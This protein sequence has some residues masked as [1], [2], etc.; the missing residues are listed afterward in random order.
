M[1]KLEQLSIFR[2][3]K[4]TFSGDPN[5]LHI[6]IVPITSTF[7]ITNALFVYLII[8]SWYKIEY[9]YT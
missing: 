2:Y 3:F 5:D 7:K 6:C 1:W 8:N 4:F 9:I